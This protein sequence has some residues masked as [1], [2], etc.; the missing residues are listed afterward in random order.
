MLLEGRNVLVLI[1]APTL[2]ALS[3]LGSLSME[4]MRAVTSAFDRNMGKKKS[5]DRKRAVSRVCVCVRSERGGYRNLL[6]CR[7]GRKKG[8]GRRRK[9]ELRLQVLNPAK[10]FP[11]P[12]ESTLQYLAFI[13]LPLRAS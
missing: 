2:Q 12:T 3:R 6:H 5:S 11:F 9:K 13:C 8:E 1:L 10:S 7:M 4:D